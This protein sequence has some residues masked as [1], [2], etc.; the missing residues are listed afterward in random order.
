MKSGKTP[1]ARSSDAQPAARASHASAVA[2]GAPVPP[3]PWPQRRIDPS[4][5]SPCSRSGL[6]RRVVFYFLGRRDTSTGG[7][8]ASGRPAVSV[9]T[10]ENPSGSE[11]ARWLTAGLPGMLVTGLGQTP[12]LDVVSIARIEEVLKQLNVAD[13]AAIDKG[14]VLE[15]GRRAGAGAMVVGAVFKTGAEFRIDVQVQDVAS[16][17]LLGA[18]SARGA[19]IFAL[20]DDLTGRILGN[21]N[22]RPTNG[23]RGVAQVTSSSTE[24]YRLTPKG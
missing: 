7:I 13:G 10:F 3:T 21:L 1:A 24:A 5:P 22:V 14:R 8:G 17:R 15:V 9:V 16:G 12:G 20:A 11:E 23:T 4:P 18:H 6:P 19:D 2:D